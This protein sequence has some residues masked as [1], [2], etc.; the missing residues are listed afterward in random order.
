MSRHRNIRNYAYE[1]DM[2][3]DVYGH[4]VEEH[5][6]CVSPTT[7]QQ[8]MYRRGETQHRNLSSFMEEPADYEDNKYLDQSEHLGA[9]KDYEIP[10]LSRED[11]AKL[12]SC[13]DEFR[14]ILG[15]H[16]DEQEAKAAILKHNFDLERALDEVLDQGGNQDLKSHN[17]PRKEKDVL[18]FEHV[19]NLHSEHGLGARSQ[20]EIGQAGTKQNFEKPLQNINKVKMFSERSVLNAEETTGKGGPT[21]QSLFSSNAK[22]QN[23]PLK[24][25]SRTEKSKK[26][27][28]S[29]KSVRS[30]AASKKL[31]E[32]S[33]VARVVY[34][35]TGSLFAKESSTGCGVSKN[36]GRDTLPLGQ[37]LKT[38]QTLES[39]DSQVSPLSMH[40]GLKET[41]SNIRPT[42]SSPV[43]GSQF[44]PSL[45]NLSQSTETKYSSGDD[46]GKTSSSDRR[47]GSLM[48]SPLSASKVQNTSPLSKKLASKQ[49]SKDMKGISVQVS[50][51]M[52]PSLVHIP[53][54]DESSIS[55]LT[56]LK[57]ERSLND[58]T[59]GTLSGDK[60]NT[61]NT[62]R[63]LVHIP[64]NDGC[65][66]RLLRARQ[67]PKRDDCVS[68]VGLENNNNSNLNIG[69]GETSDKAKSGLS[70][71]KP[72]TTF[73][74]SGKTEN[75]GLSSSFS[76]MKINLSEKSGKDEGLS[77]TRS[78][79]RESSTS[80][81]EDDFLIDFEQDV[82]SGES[83]F[84]FLHGPSTFA[85]T[86]LVYYEKPGPKW[87]PDVTRRFQNDF[88]IVPFDFSTAS[89]DDFV[90]A[91]QKKARLQRK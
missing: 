20:H 78:D 87:K 58:K 16:C 77:A 14:S 38:H 28:E 57:A 39:K 1:E 12:L 9:V 56:R 80:D 53:S 86:L 13:M 75:A 55:P 90:L 31:V 29:I 81:V 88:A 85:C 44:K 48:T 50:T 47:N 72:L 22:L 45:S 76:R 17:V 19:N 15:D 68:K 11:E 42:L 70:T 10:K 7:A 30:I 36:E 43:I 59:F 41:Q 51:K 35:K 40:R 26:Q 49:E 33:F 67:S 24:E 34:E 46:L 63:A 79:S 60:A 69:V 4:S 21:E 23:S 82:S 2:Y 73:P 62:A 66:G 83:V 64:T 84:E 27:R 91:K 32:N 71:M 3:E 18:K 54:V 25:L 8:F 6:L 89:P 65:L 37:L 61:D 5:D 74:V 52:P